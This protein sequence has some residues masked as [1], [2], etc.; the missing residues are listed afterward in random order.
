MKYIREI[1]LA[2]FAAA[3]CA[4]AAWAQAGAPSAPVPV[5]IATAKRVFISNMGTDAMSTAAFKKEQ[6]ENKPYNEFYAAVKTWGRY[7]LVDT[8]ADADLIYEIGFNAPI[9]G[10]GEPVVYG[11]QFN[12]SIVDAKTHFR[13][14]TLYAAVG[15]ALRKVT[16]DKNFTTGMTS[17]VDD[18]KKLSARGDAGTAESANK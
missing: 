7:Q 2:W 12:L 9:V 4:S 6:A 13:L 5:Q 8:P 18:L 1:G 11:P 16:W 17:L 14:W 10:G 3:L 15:G